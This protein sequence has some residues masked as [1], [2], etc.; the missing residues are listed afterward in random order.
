MTQKEIYHTLIWFRKIFYECSYEDGFTY[1]LTVNRFRI[2]P[3]IRSDS[4]SFQ[5]ACNVAKEYGFI[6]D[7]DGYI[8]DFKIE[9]LTKNRHLLTGTELGLL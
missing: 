6:L 9:N 8:I 4:L 7:D 2:S 1:Y 5:E 3:L